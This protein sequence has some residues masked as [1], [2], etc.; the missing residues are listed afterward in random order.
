MYISAI[1]EL[2]TKKEYSVPV[3]SK[4]EKK[5]DGESIVEEIIFSKVRHENKEYFVV[6]LI[7]AALRRPS[8]NG[9]EINAKD[10]LNALRLH[11]LT[12]VQSKE[13]YL[14]IKPD[15][16]TTHLLKASDKFKNMDISLPLERIHQE[17]VIRKNAAFGK[18]SSLVSIQIPMDI[19]DLLR[20]Y[21]ESQ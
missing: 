15:Q 20:G 21:D 9:N 13:W 2:S 4:A 16:A 1:L 11:G 12:V 6:D 7:D 5:S 3:W 8:I 17:R 10:A 19:I 14:A 18:N